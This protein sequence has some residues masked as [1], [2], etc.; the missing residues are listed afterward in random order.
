ML[1]L[2]GSW[3]RRDIFVKFARGGLGHM[4]LG[5]RPHDYALAPPIRPRDFEDITHVDVSVGFGGL[6]ADVDFAAFAGLL[7]VR[8]G[9]E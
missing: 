8:A 6:A 3:R 5:N 4:L 1:D 9:L 2:F 7:S